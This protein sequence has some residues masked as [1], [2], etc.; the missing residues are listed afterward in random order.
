MR[1]EQRRAASRM[2]PLRRRQYHEAFTG[3]SPCLTGSSGL[4]RFRD[5]L[6]TLYSHRTSVPGR[7]HN[8]GRYKSGPMH[9]R[10]L[11]MGFEPH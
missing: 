3:V 6:E 4:L 5:M 2:H 7:L 9:P 10:G 11:S 8:Q 1:Q